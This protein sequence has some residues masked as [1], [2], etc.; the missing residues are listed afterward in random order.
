MIIVYM[1]QQMFILIILTKL[2]GILLFNVLSRI[3]EFREARGWSVYKLAKLSGIPQS[4]I[5]TW[6]QKNLMPPV[7][8]LEIICDTFDI[9]L[10]EFF[11][12]ENTVGHTNQ[13]SEMLEKWRLLPE[14]Q[15]QI[16]LQ[17]LDSMIQK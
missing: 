10:S 7:D 5:A 12:N 11:R 15:K 9:S 4:T 16:F 1:Y 14:N 13:Q 2:E 17:L 6:Y 8:K 3:D